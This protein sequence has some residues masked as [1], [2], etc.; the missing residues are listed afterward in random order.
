MSRLSIKQLTHSHAT[1]KLGLSLCAFLLTGLSLNG[2]HAQERWFKIE[3][4][5]F[6]NELAADRDE[7]RWTP[8]QLELQF[9]NR[10]RR[11]DSLLGHFFTPALI[12]ETDIAD[13]SFSG[14][15][16]D[17]PELTPQQQLREFI[18]LTGP[19]PSESGDAYRV[20]D[21]DRDAFIRLPDSE[22]NFQQSNRAIDRSA[23]HRLLYHAVWRQ[24]VRQATA[25]NHIFIAAGQQYSGHSELEGSLGIYFNRSEDR[26]VADAN[27]WLSEFTSLPVADDESPWL[28]PNRPASLSALPYENTPSLENEANAITYR[29]SRIFHMQQ[30]R[31]MRSAEFHYLDHPALGIVITVEPY[32]VPDLPEPEPELTEGPLPLPSN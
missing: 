23:E 24:P 18:A 3:V 17:E 11:L 7:E 26:V 6:T 22:S 20:P 10:I 15:D 19:F 1:R 28:L 31:E 16:A 27:L 29:P 32:E 9:P 21:L 14:I 8:E 30:T 5:V 25:S 2:A 12:P 13:D 4:S